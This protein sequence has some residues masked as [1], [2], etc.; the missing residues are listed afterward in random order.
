MDDSKSLKLSVFDQPASDHDA[1][2]GVNAVPT[3]TVFGFLSCAKFMNTLMPAPRLF[4]IHDPMCSWCYAFSASLQ[5]LQQ[6]LPASIEFVYLLGGLAP[7][8]STP[9]PIEMQQAIQQTWRRI[10]TRVPGVM[11]NFDFWRLNTPVRSTY[12]ACRALLAARRQGADY[13]TRLLRAI[14][15]AYYQQARNPSLIPTLQACAAEIGL[16]CVAF[17]QDLLSPAIAVELAQEIQSARAMGVSAYPTLRLVQGGK[18]ISINIDYVDHQNM[19][20]EIARGL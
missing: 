2:A 13:E 9:M 5:A 19:L 18:Q 11:F 1:S 12:P 20:A 15:L 17:N 4:Y 10:E 3:M 14:Q 6:D 8:T 16:D 7:D